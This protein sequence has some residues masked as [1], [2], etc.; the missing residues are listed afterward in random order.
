M[1]GTHTLARC[2]GFLSLL[3]FAWILHSLAQKV[4]SSRN[5]AF[6]YLAAQEDAEKIRCRQANQLL[7]PFTSVG[8]REGLFRYQ[9]KLCRRESLQWLSA[10]RI[11]L[12][13]GARDPAWVASAT[14]SHANGIYS[15]AG[16]QRL[17]GSR[18]VDFQ[19]EAKTAGEGGQEI[20]LLDVLTQAPARLYLHAQ[21]STEADPVAGLLWIEEATKDSGGQTELRAVVGRYELPPAA[22]LPTRAELL[23][24]TWGLGFKGGRII[25]GILV[26]AAAFWLCGLLLLRRSGA[27]AAAA[28]AGSLAFSVLLVYAVLSPP[29]QGPDEPDHVLSFAG[30]VNDK[31]L[32]SSTLDLANASH[33]E[34]IKFR[35]EEKFSVVDVGR[36]LKGTWAPHIYGYAADR[37]PLALVIWRVVNSAVMPLAAGPA[38]LALRLSNGLFVGL[39]LLIA[40]V[41]A[42]LALR[43]DASVL[44][45]AFPAVLVPSIAYFGVMVSNYAYLVG[46][47]LIQTVAFGLLWQGLGIEKPSARFYAAAGGLAGFGTALAAGA[48]DN[49]FVSFIFWGIVLPVYAALSSC[50]AGWRHSAVL[51]TSFALAFPLYCLAINLCVYDKLCVAPR[52][53]E[54]L[55]RYISPAWCGPTGV[56]MFFLFAYLAV[57]FAASALLGVVGYTGNL[58]GLAAWGRRLFVAGVFGATVFVLAGVASGVPDIQAAVE[59]PPLLEYAKTVLHA[60]VDGLGPGPADWYIVNHFWGSLGWL[61]TV[62]PWWLITFMRIATGL[63]LFALCVSSLLRGAP[64]NSILLTTASLAGILAMLVATVVL[65]HSYYAITVNVHGRYL[66]GIYLFVLVLA[67]E[68]YRRIFAKWFSSYLLPFSAASAACL[69]A[70]S[71]QSV[72]WTTILNRYLQ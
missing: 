45:L 32:T 6:F 12:K 62:L 60:F 34:R 21:R 69:L 51:L 71:I 2:A 72:S 1:M 22:D 66:L 14:L 55:Q 35:P 8:N 31:I 49:G 67:A 13:I 59:R 39:C 17:E 9:L 15:T 11:S 47:F 64:R 56:L 30:A 16:P 70:A 53:L 44:V 54:F 5:E 4:S 18:F 50:Q 10:P 46:G 63:G 42:A 24:F 68:G 33:F 20:L 3:A 43:S 19:A 29:L 37:S 26:A 48:A 40:L 41:C 52:A 57:V 25:H 65:Y 36:P 23:G 27:L 38:I 58:A 61:D 28:G 7:V